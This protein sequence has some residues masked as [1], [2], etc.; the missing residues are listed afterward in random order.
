[1]GRSLVTAVVAFAFS[2]SAHA[3]TPCTNAAPLPNATAQ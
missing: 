1:M 2:V 3:A